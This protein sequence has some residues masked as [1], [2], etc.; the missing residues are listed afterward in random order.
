MAKRL[1]IL[2]HAKSSWTSG[3][4][5]DHARPL[6]KRGRRDSPRVGARLRDMG[7]I[8]DR[9]IASDSQ[10]TRETW[11][12]MAA[13]FPHAIEARFTRD[14]YHGG[15]SAIR[16]H[17]SALDDACATALVLGHNL[18]WEAAVER[19]SGRWARMTTANAA[20]LACEAD[21]WETAMDNRWEL[22]GVIRPKEL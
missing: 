11:Q 12:R 19:L 16:N 3:A 10:R 17:C 13:A 2:R 6:N 5:T 20:L 9:V 1:I 21:R 14:F 8:P 7:W 18:G 4:P 15:I 22:V